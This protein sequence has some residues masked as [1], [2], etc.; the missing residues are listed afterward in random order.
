MKKFLFIV[1]GMLSLQ[2]KP[3]NAQDNTTTEIKKT[4]IIGNLLYIPNSKNVYLATS[5]CDNNQLYK[6]QFDDKNWEFETRNFGGTKLQQKMALSLIGKEKIEF[7]KKVEAHNLSNIGVFVEKLFESQN[8]LF[9][10]DQNFF[11]K[12]GIIY[13]D[14]NTLFHSLKLNE[15]V[16]ISIGYIM[17]KESDKFQVFYK[18]SENDE[19]IEIFSGDLSL[20]NKNNV[21]TLSYQKDEENLSLVVKVDSKYIVYAYHTG[22]KL[23]YPEKLESKNRYAEIGKTTRGLRSVPA[24]LLLDIINKDSSFIISRNEI[25]DLSSKGKFTTPKKAGVDTITMS[26][27]SLKK[28]DLF[29]YLYNGGK[30]NYNDTLVVLN[31]F[32][33]NTFTG[34]FGENKNEFVLTSFPYDPKLGMIEFQGQKTNFDEMIELCPNAPDV[35]RR[36]EALNNRLETI[37]RNS[38]IEDAKINR[39]Q[40]IIEEA[41]DE[42]GLEV[43]NIKVLKDCKLFDISDDN[44][45]KAISELVSEVREKRSIASSELS[46]VISEFT[47]VN[48]QIKGLC[49]SVE[50]VDPSAPKFLT[51]MANVADKA[52]KGVL[53]AQ[54]VGTASKATELFNSV[55]ASKEQLDNAKKVIDNYKKATN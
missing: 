42:S 28:K 6:L 24:I 38:A 30:Y 17:V 39:F 34:Y 32:K 7:V 5:G 11:D 44:N 14:G 55:K 43:T 26:S 54:L 53:Q 20:F 36:I 45:R 33:E 52:S 13:L 31:N 35:V 51:K 50:E 15:F 48:A 25:S 8:K 4:E 23:F 19:P 47:A 29:T 41:K 49:K 1:V 2:A 16:P 46:N 3:L 10:L 9:L 27:S 21:S 12:D 40:F 18:L 22:Q 37:K